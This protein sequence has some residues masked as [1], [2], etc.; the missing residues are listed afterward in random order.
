M[1]VSCVCDW[2]LIIFQEFQAL[3]QAMSTLFF[4]LKKKIF[5]CDDF[6]TNNFEIF[7]VNMCQPCWILNFF[8]CLSHV[9][10]FNFNFNFN[11]C[12]TCYECG[13]SLNFI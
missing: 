13:M 12:L 2:T 4:F 11:M 5:L 7:H 8:F 6:N 10:T 9:L 1:C 3:L